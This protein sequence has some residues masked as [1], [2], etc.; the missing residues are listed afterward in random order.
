M[1]N[2]LFWLSK[3]WFV[4]LPTLT[5]QNLI[6]EITNF[7]NRVSR[8]YELT[9]YQMVNVS[10]TTSK[11]VRLVQICLENARLWLIIASV[12]ELPDLTI[13]CTAGRLQFCKLQKSEWS[14]WNILISI[15]TL[16]INNY[17]IG[18]LSA[19]VFKSTKTV[20]IQVRKKYY[21]K[22]E[23]KYFKNQQKSKC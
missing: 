17:F 6:C 3:T 7:A 19:P 11:R 1:S 12:G 9:V 13:V 21:P 4:K 18:Q 15:E 14:I 2:N 5:F 22:G 23:G 10:S 20:L 8:H 16:K